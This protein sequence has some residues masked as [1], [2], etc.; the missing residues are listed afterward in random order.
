MRGVQHSALNCEFDGHGCNG[1]TP[2][3]KKGHILGGL[4]LNLPCG[5]LCMVNQAVHCAASEDTPQYFILVSH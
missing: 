5:A 2:P 3:Q 4:Y 1:T